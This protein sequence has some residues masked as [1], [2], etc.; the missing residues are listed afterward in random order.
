MSKAKPSRLVCYIRMHVSER[1]NTESLFD[2][3]MGCQTIPKECYRH[4]WKQTKPIARLNTSTLDNALL[5][6]VWWLFHLRLKTIF[7]QWKTHHTCIRPVSVFVYGL[8]NEPHC[9]GTGIWRRK[10]THIFI[11]CFHSRLFFSSLS[12]VARALFS[13]SS[14]CTDVWLPLFL[15]LAC[16]R[17]LPTENILINE[18]VWK[19]MWESEKPSVCECI[20][21]RRERISFRF[22]NISWTVSRRSFVALIAIR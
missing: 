20:F 22:I 5:F 11:F 2:P 9:R 12:S 17:A 6:W 10:K 1:A 4:M 13:S 3:C 8:H 14:V 21:E 7:R 19:T 18:N 16:A 15:S